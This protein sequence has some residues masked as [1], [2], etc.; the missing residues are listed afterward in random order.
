[1]ESAIPKIILTSIY[2]E[3]QD[4]SYQLKYFSKISGAHFSLDRN[5]ALIKK[6]KR[7]LA[8]KTLNEIK[9]NMNLAV[10]TQA[11]VEALFLEHQAI[12]ESQFNQYRQPRFMKVVYV[13]Q[14]TDQLWDG[15]PIIEPTKRMREYKKQDVDW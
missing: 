1:L 5:I 6:K 3:K 8:D 14:F 9:V 13:D 10:K 4:D 11:S 12:S 15:Y 2:F 7:W